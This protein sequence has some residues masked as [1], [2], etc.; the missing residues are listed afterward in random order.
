MLKIYEFNQFTNLDTLNGKFIEQ[1][2]IHCVTIYCGG[3]DSTLQNKKG[4]CKK[5]CMIMI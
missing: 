2:V 1:Y 5:Q 3:F 4:K